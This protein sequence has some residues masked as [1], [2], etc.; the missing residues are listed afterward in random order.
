MSLSLIDILT[1]LKLSKEKYT[2]ELNYQLLQSYFEK[3]EITESEFVASDYITILLDIVSKD[4]HDPAAIIAQYAFETFS[5][6]TSGILFPEPVS[7]QFQL[8]LQQ[9]NNFSKCMESIFYHL[10]HKTD[11]ILTSFSLFFISEQ[12]LPILMLTFLFRLLISIIKYFESS[13]TKP[14]K[15]YALKA[16]ANLYEQLPSEVLSYSPLWVSK[17]VNI[18][19]SN[20]SKGGIYINDNNENTANDLRIQSIGIEIFRKLSESDLY[21][22]NAYFKDHSSELM[23]YLM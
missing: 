9:I 18:F 10:D 6:L 22:L 13:T 12:N 4:L 1:T 5:K 21:P 16:F 8:Q 2:K 23:Q 20:N 7:L 17:F 11:D 19:L 15:L 3:N 14:I